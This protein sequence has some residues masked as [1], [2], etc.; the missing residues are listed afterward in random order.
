MNQAYALFLLLCNKSCY[1]K[2]TYQA[3]FPP[4]EWL[5]AECLLEATVE[6]PSLLN[7]NEHVMLYVALRRPCLQYM[8]ITI[9]NDSCSQHKM[10]HCCFYLSFFFF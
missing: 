3:I 5:E 4:C 1:C 8:E 9:M 6:I 2:R 10:Q 7:P